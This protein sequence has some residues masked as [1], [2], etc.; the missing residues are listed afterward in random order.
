MT[1][2]YFKNT[3]EYCAFAHVSFVDLKTFSYVS[4]LFLCERTAKLE[5]LLVQCAVNTWG[6]IEENIAHRRVTF[7]NNK[8]HLCWM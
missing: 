8:K 1:Y 7:S 6:K 5:N 2:N 4:S 3:F